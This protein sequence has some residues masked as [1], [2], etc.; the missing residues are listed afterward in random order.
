[1]YSLGEKGAGDEGRAEVGS[2][3]AGMMRPFELEALVAQK[4]AYTSKRRRTT[5]RRAPLTP[6]PP[7]PFE[8]K[9]ERGRRCESRTLLNGKIT[10]RVKYRDLNC[11]RLK[12]KVCYSCRVHLA[13]LRLRI[14]GQVYE[15]ITEEMKY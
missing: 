10:L 8:Y 14:A 2:V 1:M 6:R 12:P 4:R 5:S 15:R 3:D 7:L 11:Q 13:G 9:G